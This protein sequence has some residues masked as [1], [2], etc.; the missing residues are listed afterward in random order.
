MSQTRGVA[1]PPPPS[2]PHLRIFYVLPPIYQYVIFTNLLNGNSVVTHKIVYIYFFPKL[3]KFQF[4]GPQICQI[5]IQLITL[6]QKSKRN[7]SYSECKYL[8]VSSR[9]SINE[10]VRVPEPVPWHHA[11]DKLLHT[12]HVILHHPKRPWCASINE[13][14]HIS[15]MGREIRSTS[16]RHVSYWNAFL[17]AVCASNGSAYMLPSL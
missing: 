12:A 5:A 14:I 4:G 11:V 15:S 9:S 10:E 13:S 2:P 1:V 6:K 17:C 16:R 3:T 8:H 7:L